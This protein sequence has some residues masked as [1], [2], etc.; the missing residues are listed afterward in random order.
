MIPFKEF[1]SEEKHVGL[2]YHFTYLYSACEIVADN[3][4]GRTYAFDKSLE[5]KVSITRDQ[6]FH[7]HNRVCIGTQVR[8][9]LDGT[10]LS[11]RYKI[12]PY[13]D[14]KKEY[15]SMLSCY[16]SEEVIDRN[17]RNLNEYL[18]RI[19]VVKSLC[20]DMEYPTY[21]RINGN[22]IDINK[23]EDF[24]ILLKKLS[25]VPVGIIS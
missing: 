4:I 11:R 15:H 18:I 3:K 20:G 23:F 9:T 16:E 24:I 1:I 13:N 14:F 7:R 2:R 25:N 5:K 10:K 8:F 22:D 19:D 21:V 12:R 17:I 6:F